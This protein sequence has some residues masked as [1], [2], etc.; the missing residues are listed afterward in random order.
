MDLGNKGRAFGIL[1][2][3][4]SIGIV[5]ALVLVLAPEVQID[6]FPHALHFWSKNNN[7]NLWS[8]SKKIHIWGIATPFNK[9]IEAGV[10]LKS[11][12]AGRSQA[13]YKLVAT[14]RANSN[15][16]SFNDD[17]KA[18]RLQCGNVLIA[19]RET[20]RGLLSVEN[21]KY[22]VM[23]QT[24]STLWEIFEALHRLGKRIQHGIITLL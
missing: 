23:Q 24:L 21:L 14:K 9:G 8:K 2:K 18:G 15:L 3:G 17:G 12:N 6:L 4:I 19:A 10:F 16:G 1:D 13:F 20:R 7:G 11:R 5:V 22:G